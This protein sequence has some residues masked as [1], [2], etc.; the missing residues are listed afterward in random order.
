M[1][2]EAQSRIERG[3]I[4]RVIASETPV[5]YDDGKTPIGVFFEK[6]H[7]KYVRYED[8]PKVFVKALIASEDKNFFEHSGFDIKAILRS[9]VANLQAGKVVQGGSTLTQQTAKNIFE[10]EKRSYK[11]KFKELIQAFLLEM[12]Y[13]KQEIIEMYANQFFVTGYGKGLQI[14]SNYFFGK[15]AQD[16]DLVEAAF[17]VGSV[18]GPNRYNPFIKKTPSEKEKARRLAKER[19]DYVLSNMLEMNFITEREY[20]EAKKREVP[21]QE[22]QITYRLNVV[23]D[24]VREQLESAYFKERLEDQGIKN[25]ATAGLRIYTSVNKNMQEAALES[26]RTHL[27]ILDVQLSG[28]DPMARLEQW[29]DL[30][31]HGLRKSKNQLPF[32]A[33]ITDVDRS[34]ENGRLMVKWEN[35]GGVIDY[36]GFKEMGEAWLKGKLGPWTRFDREH[37]PVF[38]KNFQ[39]GDLVPVRLMENPETAPQEQA[40]PLLKLAMIPELEGGIVVLHRGMVK[41]MV[42]GFFDHFF[43]RAVDAKRQLGSIFKPIV[44]AAALALKWNLLDPLRNQRDLFQ[45]QDTAYIPRPDHE[46]KSDTVSLAW[47]GIKSENLATVW[48]LYHLTDHLNMSEF[49][50]LTELLG[51][52]R[53]KDEPYTA[54]KE[55]IRDRYGIVVNREA[56]MKA[57]FESARSEVETDLIFSGRERFLSDLRHIKFD[58]HTDAL[59]MEKPEV[60]Q[61]ARYNFQELRR[62]SRDMASQFSAI[63][64]LLTGGHTKSLTPEQIERLRAGL[65]HLYRTVG[66]GHRSQL[67]YTKHPAALEPPALVAVTPRWL[68]EKMPGTNMES[69][70][71]IDGLIPAGIVTLLE[72][73]MVTNYKGLLGH[74][75]YSLDIL[76]RIRDFRTLVNLSFVV[77]FSKKIGIST[78]LDPVLSF[79]LGPNAVSIMEA[80]IAYE[81]LLTGRVY[82]LSSDG[83]ETMV[84]IITKIEDREG[85]VIW[86][87]QPLVRQV[88]SERASHLIREI[89]KKV[90]TWGTGSKAR[91]AVTL[92]DV[93]V[94]TYGK[95]GTANRYTNS[96]FVGMVPGLDRPSGKPV[97]EDGYVIASYVGYDDNRPMKGKHI[98]I[99]GSAGALPLWIDTADAI[100]SSAE[101]R[102]GLEPADLA[103]G[104]VE[105]EV[106]APDW[107]AVPVSPVSGLPV[108]PTAEKSHKAPPEIRT[109][110]IV[111]GD[112]IKLKRIFEPSY[113][114]PS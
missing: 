7:R 45:F 18:K 36:D 71:L 24:Y 89:L 68:L 11:A 41:T 111:D 52:A 43:N 50:R 108:S 15:D 80:A 109:E 91:D 79:P 14:A 67:V 37:A 107:V 66:E 40:S 88:L 76:S 35:G 81:T 58:I 75:R 93:R 101:Y 59:E 96:S 31:K 77:Y 49:R 20:S 26:L 2:R 42:G 44:Y 110:A 85:K 19:K 100:V 104:I 3:A 23:L 48:L 92:Y 90:M 87:Y 112:D 78:P 21:F 99:Y 13:S 113:G 17:I 98:S 51:L 83:D 62:L 114:E 86:A 102:K 34:R 1:S 84:P 39:K 57:A 5:F 63:E 27:P 65:R 106:V 54:Y 94:P 72:K 64:P 70:V 95:T 82:P 47:A 25:I 6:T 32:L 61:I 103:F 73:N 30:V 4:D 16:L 38:L 56:L 60:R 28:Y 29:E 55:R 69:R 33:E 10:R 105:A 22:G 74:R 9:L 8:M 53:E 12:Q 46:P 97:L